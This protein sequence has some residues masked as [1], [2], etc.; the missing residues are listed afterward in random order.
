MTPCPCCGEELDRSRLPDFVEVF[1]PPQLGDLTV[2]VYCE[3]WLQFTSI[4]PYEFH[5]LTTEE[6]ANLL[7]EE[8]TAM[9]RTQRIARE[10]R[11]RMEARKR[12]WGVRA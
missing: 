3:A 6:K 1:E 8:Y 2:C 7:A 11:L 5:A 12:E 10:I 9:V 4:E